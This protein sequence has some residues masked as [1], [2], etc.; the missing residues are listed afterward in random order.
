M[1]LYW[2]LYCSTNH[3]LLNEVGVSLWLE[4]LGSRE[5]E[6]VSYYLSILSEAYTHGNNSTIFP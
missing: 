1:S 6:D 4:I 3:V 2:L 5:Q